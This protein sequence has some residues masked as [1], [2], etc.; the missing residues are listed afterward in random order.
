MYNLNNIIFNQKYKFFQKIFN[1]VQ[2]LKTPIE[3]IYSLKISVNLTISS[4]L[5]SP[6]LAILNVP[7]LPNFPG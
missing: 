3:A 5:I 4:G 6:I 7:M 2:P 1:K